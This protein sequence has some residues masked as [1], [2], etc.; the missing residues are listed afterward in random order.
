MLH[1]MEAT[2]T[3]R[4][5]PR[6]SSTSVRRGVD[7][8]LLVD[9]RAATEKGRATREA[10]GAVAEALGVAPSLLRVKAGARSRVKVLA[11]EGLERED[12]DGR[13]SRI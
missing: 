12:L 1:L 6:S 7:Q 2:F 10:I 13:L 9:V 11:V 5:R 3:V 4:V 8:D